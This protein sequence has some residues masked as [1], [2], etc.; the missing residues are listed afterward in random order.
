MSLLSPLVPA[1]PNNLTNGTPADASQVMADFNNLRNAINNVLNATGA[2]GGDQYVGITTNVRYQGTSVYDAL[3]QIADR[4]FKQDT[5]TVNALVVTCAPAVTSYYDGLTI[6]VKAANTNTSTTPTLNVNGVGAKGIVNQNG[7]VQMDVGSLVATGNYIFVYNTSVLSGAGGWV[8][9]NPSGAT[10]SFTLTVN[11]MTSATTGTC[12]YRTSSDT[13]FL[14][15]WF[16]GGITG[17][18]NAATMTG[19]GMP[20]NLI[21]AHNKEVVGWLEDN[22]QV[23]Q[24]LINIST[25]TWTFG[26][27]I[28]AAG[29][30][31]TS[32]I[33][34][35]NSPNGVPVWPV[36]SRD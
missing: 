14:L 29:G 17:T 12:F 16:Q 22:G 9:I 3:T 31:T 1:F 5:G 24:G 20:S 21:F 4:Q 25:S 11:G 34:G 32:G 30:F 27:A 15:I 8:C 2:T 18:S 35:I 33:K 10:G 23:V 36:I 19:T 28:T 7:L 13:G 26:K 6:L